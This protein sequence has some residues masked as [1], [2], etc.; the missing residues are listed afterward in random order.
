M[1]AYEKKLN[2][3][4]L[5]EVERLTQVAASAFESGTNSMDLL[6]KQVAA[7]R[8]EIEQLRNQQR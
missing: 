5:Q 3:S 8:K 1:N 2:L 6:K 7:Q 4:F